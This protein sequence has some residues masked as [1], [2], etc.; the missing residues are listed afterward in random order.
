[1]SAP[2][3]LQALAARV[4]AA[5]PRRTRR[6]VALAGPPGS[7]KSTL[8]RRLSGQ[9][10]E[11]GHAAPVVPMDGFHLDNRL[12]SARGLL[13]R[14]GAPE[15]FDVAGLLRLVDALAAG[16]EVIHPVFDRARDS[17]IAGAGAV[18]ETDR[19]A[20]LE[21]NYLLFD[22]PPWRA[23][24]GF[25]DVSVFLAVPEED[26]LSRLTT[27]WL[28]HGLAPEAARDRAERNDMA[29]ARLVAARRLPADLALGTA[30][31]LPGTRTPA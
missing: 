14:K 18:A 16:G 5:P 4:L 24:A 6:L 9:L 10:A 27:R 30:E 8:A 21:G 25:W 12:L 29:N 31:P 19:T 22:A 20:I 13:A 7:G 15:S 17:A 26:L 1:M 11:M 2:P 3:D 28:D 23:L